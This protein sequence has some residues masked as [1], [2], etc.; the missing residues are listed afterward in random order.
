MPNILPHVPLHYF[1][2]NILLDDPHGIHD[3]SSS[4]AVLLCLAE[5]STCTVCLK[6]NRPFIATPFQVMSRCVVLHMLLLDY[7]L[8]VFYLLIYPILLFVIQLMANLMG[9]T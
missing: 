7:L 4:A 6:H 5:T 8:L 2:T 3:A 9:L 1:V